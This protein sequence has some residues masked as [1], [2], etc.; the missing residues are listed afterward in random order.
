MASGELP[1]LQEL[2]LDAA[3]CR[4]FARVAKAAGSAQ[5][6]VVLV[7][8][9]GVSSRYLVPTAR[10]LA[11]DFAVYA[12]DLPGFGLSQK[13]RPPLD[14][15]QLAEALLAWMDAAQVEQAA[16][17]GNSLGCQIIAEVAVRQPERVTRAV[18]AGPTVDAEA[19][20]ALRQLWRLLKDA[21][22]EAPSLVPVVTLDYLRCG[23]GRAWRTLRF[24]L[25]DRIETKLP[26]MTCPTLVVNGERD[27]IVPHRWAEQVTQ[28]LPQG[29]LA[30]I[31]RGPHAVNYSTPD[32]LAN[33]TREFLNQAIA[34]E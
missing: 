20:S 5:T 8:G 27:P 12:P 21:P 15:G 4:M 33:L 24:A 25:A 29:R 1:S 14:V 34:R 13:P 32:A 17:L 18:L 30:V 6:P 10:R 22:R 7:H 11:R 9:L 23:L 3:G 16:L 31:P 28:L 26:R 19:R 2:W